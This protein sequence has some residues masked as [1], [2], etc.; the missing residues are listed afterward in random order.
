MKAC[1]R[2]NFCCKV[3]AIDE[4][5]K[6]FGVWCPHARPGQGCAI[7][8]EHPASCRAFA[9]LWLTEDGLPDAYRPDRTKVVLTAEDEAQPR[10]IANCE[11]ANPLAWAQEPIYSLLKARARET[12][13][14]GS[15]VLAKAGLRLWLITPNADMDL[16]EV[17]TRSPVLVEQDPLGEI[18]VTVQPPRPAA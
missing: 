14:T 17:E 11:P 6:P 15:V 12:W 1:G 7:Y 10:L 3:M 5:A 8:G 2:C 4:L 16:G 9:C 13:G 18:R